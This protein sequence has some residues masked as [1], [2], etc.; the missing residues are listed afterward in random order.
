MPTR[1]RINWRNMTDIAELKTRKMPLNL[2]IVYVE[3]ELAIYWRGPA[4]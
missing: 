3:I 1:R 2:A 4:A